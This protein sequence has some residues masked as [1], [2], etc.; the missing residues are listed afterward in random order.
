MTFDTTK[1]VTFRRTRQTNKGLLVQAGISVSIGLVFWFIP[2]E[3]PGGIIINL[4]GV[5][6]LGFI[7]S[8]YLIRLIVRFLNSRKDVIEIGPN[9]I[10]DERIALGRIP[11]SAV[12]EIFVAFDGQV[13][14]GVD[15]AVLRQIGQP[16][17]ARFK[18]HPR[19]HRGIDIISLDHTDFV[20]DP[21]EFVKTLGA[22]AKAAKAPAAMSGDLPFEEQE[23]IGAADTT[24]TVTYKRVTYTFTKLL[25][26][27]AVVLSL[28]ALLFAAVIYDFSSVYVQM[29]GSVTAILLLDF[30]VALMVF[31]YRL[32]TGKRNVME[33]GPDGIQDDGISK[34]TIPWSAVHGIAASG[35]TTKPAIL[36]DIDET[37]LRQPGTTGAPLRAGLAVET[38]SRQLGYGSYDV[39]FDELLPTLRDYAKA[40][41][42]PAATNGKLP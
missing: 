40:Y 4:M 28:I 2:T 20:E 34:A 17:W 14:L 21:Y 42:A 30:A 41:D 36:L 37:R 23:T 5:A 9:G 31:I 29:I 33:I 10:L 38:R 26:R 19:G 18:G 1:T 13:W 39:E 35:S 22:Y 16:G 3:K 25:I 11:W 7:A 24:R 12:R 8:L 27:T 6:L 15:L 32:I